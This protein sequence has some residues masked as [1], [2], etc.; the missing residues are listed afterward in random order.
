MSLPLR[1]LWEP[2]IT[3]VKQE[4]TEMDQ[5]VW[6]IPLQAPVQENQHILIGQLHLE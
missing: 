1:Q 3:N 5:A 2:V 6:P 4:P